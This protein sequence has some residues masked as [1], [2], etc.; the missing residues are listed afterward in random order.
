M[1]LIWSASKAR[2]VLL[3][4]FPAA[5]TRNTSVA[6][7]SS[8]GASATMM[9]SYSPMVQTNSRRRP[10]WSTTCPRRARDLSALSRCHR[11]SRPNGGRGGG[12]HTT[13]WYALSVLGR[14]AGPLSPGEL[15]RRTGLTTGATTRLIDRLRVLATSGALVIAPIADVTVELVPDFSLDVDTIVNPARR[16][17]GEVL[18]SYSR[19]EVAILFDYFTRCAGIHGS[20]YRDS[21]PGGRSSSPGGAA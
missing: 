8:S 6:A 5:P 4:T 13:D 10:S 18:A 1:S 11:G 20:Q 17:L 16:L 14:L 12:L 9:K 21:S 3:R 19:D 7:V 2:M 15:A